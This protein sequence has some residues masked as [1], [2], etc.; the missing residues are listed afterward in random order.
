MVKILQLLGRWSKVLLLVEP[1]QLCGSGYAEESPSSS[2]WSR[3]RLGGRSSC[4]CWGEKVGGECGEGNSSFYVAWWPHDTYSRCEKV[5]DGGRL[6]SV[7]SLWFDS[8]YR[9]LW[10]NMWSAI[11][12][13]F[14]QSI[15]IQNW[16]GPPSVSLLISHHICRIIS[17]EREGN[18]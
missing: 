14:K 3:S 12:I 1:F 7:A 15:I 2:G 8:E 18:D 13:S 10:P 5:G 9:R 4:S 16:V 17:S 6:S 11:W